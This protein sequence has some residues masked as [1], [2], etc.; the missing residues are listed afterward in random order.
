MSIT[1]DEGQWD[2]VLESEQSF[3]EGEMGDLKKAIELLLKAQVLDGDY[4]S[5]LQKCNPNDPD[6]A[7][8]LELVF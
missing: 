8:N 2:S 7:K 6:R 1:K 3:V 5:L 4:L